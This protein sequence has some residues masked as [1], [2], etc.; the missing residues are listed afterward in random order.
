MS[1][2]VLNAEASTSTACARAWIRKLAS[3]SPDVVKWETDV[4]RENRDDPEEAWQH[5]LE[6]TDTRDQGS[7]QRPVPVTW[8]T[9]SFFSRKSVAEGCP[10]R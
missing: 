9:R 1:P 3:E 7:E 10:A 8:P 4:K 5:M 2:R 6:L